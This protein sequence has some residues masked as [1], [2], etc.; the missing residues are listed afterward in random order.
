MHHLRNDIKFRLSSHALPA[1]PFLDSRCKA[2]KNSAPLAVSVMRVTEA[3]FLAG[4][5][6][7]CANII[8]ESRRTQQASQPTPTRPLRARNEGESVS[9]SCRP[10]STWELTG[11]LAST[12]TLCALLL[13][14]ILSGKLVTWLSP[15]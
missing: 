7:C 3:C 14:S 12:S 11:T 6:Y 8:V 13:G 4:S 9:P 1:R 10:G 5:V 2:S 15:R